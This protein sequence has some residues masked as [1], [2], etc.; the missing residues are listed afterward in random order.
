M[1][2]YILG[3]II[4]ISVIFASGCISNSDEVEEPQTLTQGRVT[5]KY[6]TTWVVA[7]SKNNETIAAVADPN[8]INSNSGLGEVSVSIQKRTLNGTSLNKLYNETYSSLFSN[9][10]YNLTSEGSLTIG[11]YNASE[12][13]YTINP[14]GT[15]VVKQQKAVWIENDNDVYVILCTAPQN[16]FQNQLK[17]FDFILNSFK[18]S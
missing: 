17:N 16:D 8:S 6:P 11:G 1:K 4:V 12:C 15:G 10:D 18:L 7:D 3:I 5:I 14:N 13:V 9:S 2:K